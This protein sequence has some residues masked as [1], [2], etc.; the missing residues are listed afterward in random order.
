MWLA[1]DCCHGNAWLGLKVVPN[2]WG[3]GNMSHAHRRG[4]EIR[5]LVE[6]WRSES[7]Y[8]AR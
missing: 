2:G 6:G 1:Y 3:E 8:S 5:A 7:V 4:W